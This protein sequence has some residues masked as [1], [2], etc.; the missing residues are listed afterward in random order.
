MVGYKHRKAF[1]MLELVFVIVI[2][3][4]VS[5]I[6]AEIIADVYKS[7]ILE[8]A[9]H[10][11]SVKT[12]LAATQLAN[13]LLYAVPG[14]VIGRKTDDSYRD[15]S[16][17]DSE[18]YRILEWIGYDNDSFSAKIKPGWSGFVDLDDSNKTNL[19]TRGSDLNNTD[20]IIKNLTNGTTDIGDT[21]VF[22]PGQYDAYNVGYID[23]NG[24]SDSSGAIKVDSNSHDDDLVVED[25]TGKTISEFY[26]LSWT[27]Y[28]LV[29]TDNGDGTFDLSMYY[30]YQPWNGE[31]YTDGDSKVLVR[32]VTVF[33]FIGTDTTVRFKL[34]QEEMITNDSNITI[35]KEKAVIR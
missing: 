4:I 21:A 10:R 24:N 2:L 27:A 15:I 35:C 14:T 17:L 7:Y 11:S 12:E 26:K 13:R 8:R 19:K 23:E 25:L 9:T 18:D 20:L 30:N 28:A 5:S 16:S 31:K 1:S 6:G 33:K 32:N 29:P 3:G 22:F 34:C